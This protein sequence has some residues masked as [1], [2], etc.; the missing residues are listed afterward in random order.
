MKFNRFN[1]LSTR[2]VIFDCWRKMMEVIGGHTCPSDTF[3][4]LTLSLQTLILFFPNTPLPQLFHDS[5]AS[6]LTHHH[7]PPF[8]LFHKKMYCFVDFDFSHAIIKMSKNGTGV[9]KAKK[10]PG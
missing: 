6:F 1:V 2:F 3:L 8:F 10:Q 7:H 4:S 9:N 5:I